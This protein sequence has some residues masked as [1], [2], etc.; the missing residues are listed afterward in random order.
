MDQTIL[1][2]IVTRLEFPM[3]KSVYILS[4][5]FMILIAASFSFAAG[6]VDG[7]GSIDLGDAIIALKVCSG[8]DQSGISVNGDVN[9]DGAIGMEEALYH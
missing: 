3:K 6:D 8:I 1:R 2:S 9:N 4:I 5:V 7:N